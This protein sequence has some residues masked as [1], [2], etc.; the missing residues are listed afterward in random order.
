MIASSFKIF[1]TEWRG[2]TATILIVNCSTSINRVNRLKET[3]S[4]VGF[5][6]LSDNT[7]AGRYVGTM[8]CPTQTAQRLVS[9]TRWTLL[10]SLSSGR[11]VGG[12]HSYQFQSKMTNN[13]LLCVHRNAHQSVSQSWRDG[14]FDLSLPHL[15]QHYS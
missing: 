8:F 12:S 14:A 4:R 13:D 10:T 11:C 5:H 9:R 6:L 15:F 3:R 1:P 2:T 7:L